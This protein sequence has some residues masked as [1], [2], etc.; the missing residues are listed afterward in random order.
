MSKASSDERDAEAIDH[1][2][3]AGQHILRF[4]RGGKDRFMEDLMMRSA[5][6]RQF[7]VMGEAA[8]RVSEAFREEHPQVPWRSLVG[9]RNVLIHGYDAVDPT[10]VWDALGTPLQEAL[11]ALK[12]LGE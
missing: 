4:A 1:I 2:I 6:E 5:I 8:A 3:S 7:E 11:A 10:V 12:Q 9:F